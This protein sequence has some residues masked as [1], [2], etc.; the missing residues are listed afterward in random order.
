[1]VNK[2]S[3]TKSV[4]LFMFAE[5]KRTLKE[6]EVSSFTFQRHVTLRNVPFHVAFLLAGQ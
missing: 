4:V 5:K 1:M 6:F 3:K 2:K